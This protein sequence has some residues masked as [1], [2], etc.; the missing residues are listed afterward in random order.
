MHM[1]IIACDVERGAERDSILLYF[2][3]YASLCDSSSSGDGYADGR[4]RS[5]YGGSEA[6]S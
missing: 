6:V 5:S 4:G 2:A 1:N 3:G